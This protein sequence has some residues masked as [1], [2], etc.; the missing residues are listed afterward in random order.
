MD[1]HSVRAFAFR[2]FEC[3]LVGGRTVARSRL[4]SH[5]EDSLSYVQVRLPTHRRGAISANLLPHLIQSTTTISLGIVPFRV[6]PRQFRANPRLWDFTD[7]VN[8]SQ[9]QFWSQKFLHPKLRLGRRDLINLF[10]LFHKRKTL[11]RFVTPDSNCPEANSH[12][13]KDGLNP[14]HVTF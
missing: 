5:F 7:T 12:S 6:Y 1:N 2:R 11:T 14:A 10:S 13:L 8:F 3:P 9:P 4:G